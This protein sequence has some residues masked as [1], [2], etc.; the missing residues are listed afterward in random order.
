MKTGIIEKI[1]RMKKMDNNIRNKLFLLLLSVSMVSFLLASL[2]LFTGLYMVWNT[3]EEAGQQ[4]GNRIS[5][6]VQDF[7]ED[8]VKKKLE[9]LVEEKSSRID[10]ELEVTAGDVR[11]LSRLATRILQQPQHYN[12][13]NLPDPHDGPIRSGQVY[14]NYSDRL[15]A[16]AVYIQSTRNAQAPIRET[17][18]ETVECPIPRTEH[19]SV[20]IMPQ[21]KY[22]GRMIAIRFIPA[23]MTSGLLLYS[24]SSGLPRA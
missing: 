10:R 15:A 20:S 2:V 4:V 18:I 24:P 21:R 12:P 3:A 9:A 6:F 7:V 8:Q 23:A 22:V 16:K 19:E 5:A 17:T 13:R 14:L 1:K 11:Y